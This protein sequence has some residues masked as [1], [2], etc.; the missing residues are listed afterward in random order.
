MTPPDRIFS[1]AAAAAADTI[2]PGTGRAYKRSAVA[3][4]ELRRRRSPSLCVCVCLCTCLT[5]RQLVFTGGPASRRPVRD[6]LGRPSINLDRQDGDDD[7]SRLRHCVTA[8]ACCLLTDDGV[9][10]VARS[11]LNSLGLTRQITSPGR[12]RRLV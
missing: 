9:V 3:C 5:M 2:P 12:P 4:P 10:S 11:G 1:S 8:A 6:L 7:D